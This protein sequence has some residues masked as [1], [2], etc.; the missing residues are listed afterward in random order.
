MQIRQRDFIKTKDGLYFAV[1]DNHHPKTHIISFLRYKPSQDGDRILDGQKYKKVTSN[2]A[3]TYLEKTHPDY[4]IDWNIENKK[5]MAVPIDDIKEVY[6]PIKKLQEILETED[7]DEFLNKIRLL[8]HTFHKNTEIPYNNMGVSG[9]TLLGIQKKDTSDID[10]IIYGI[11]NHQKAI[12]YYQQ[13]KENPN[14]P[15]DKIHGKYWKQVYHKRIKDDTMTQKEFTWYENRKNN[16]GLIKN[17]LF[18]IICTKNP[19]DIR[20]ENINTKSQIIAPIKIR[21][22]IKDATYAYDSPAIY[23]ITDAHVLEGPNVK[24]DKIVSYT[25]TYVGIVKKDEEVTAKGVYEKTENKDG[26]TT[27]NLIIGT[28]REALGEYIKLE[29]INIK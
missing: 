15:L 14:S 22:K 29:N 1:T 28:T 8:A 27:N 25:H 5:S 23:Q 20:D 10:F 13:A 18:D 24:I 12:K 17:T 16:R 11:K 19:E 6:S 2:E 3:Y 26:T 4:L 9:S 21:C 7:D